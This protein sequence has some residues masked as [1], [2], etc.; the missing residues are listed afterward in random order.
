[1]AI[2]ARVGDWPRPALLHST[3]VRE[4]VLAVVRRRPGVL[5]AAWSDEDE[6][7]VIVFETEFTDTPDAW[8]AEQLEPVVDSEFFG[9]GRFTIRLSPVP[10]L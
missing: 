5:S 9:L 2:L 3:V 6:A 8:M 10:P 1:M 4:V 7:Y